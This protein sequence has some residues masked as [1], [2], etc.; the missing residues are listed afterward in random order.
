MP[1][2]P[3]V[4]TTVSGLQRVLPGLTISDVWTDLKSKRLNL[5]KFKKG[6]AGRKVRSVQRRGKNILI[7]LDKDKVIL[8]H[9]KMTG[10]LLYG[11]Y[12]KTG[13]T[14]KTT[15][16]GPLLDPYNRFIHVLF[17]LSDGKHLAFS[18]TRKFGKT[19][20]IEGDPYQSVHL[21][22]LGPEPLRKFYISEFKKALDK[23]PGWK[24]KA[25]LMDQT[26]ISGI[27]NIYS[28]EMLWYAGVHPEEREKNVPVPKLKAMFAAMKK[29]SK[30][31][32]ISAVTQ[33]LIIG[34]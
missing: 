31:G 10:H 17:T 20:L 7:F 30:K 4:Q 25:A 33:C 8:I 29:S 1:E 3:E 21:S 27:G 9:M 28:D 32:L 14:W 24:I 16:S 6:V 19:A 22:H 13:N 15:A 26:L 11:P 34:M 18:D 5:K 2:L 12:K 23:K